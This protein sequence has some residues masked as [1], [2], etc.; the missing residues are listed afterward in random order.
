LRL[1]NRAR[2]TNLEKFLTLRSITSIA[3]SESSSK[4]K[5]KSVAGK[6]AALFFSRTK[7]FGCDFARNCIG[8]VPDVCYKPWPDF[9]PSPEGFVLNQPHLN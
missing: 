2:S 5:H 7:T 1:R 3:Q 9:I 6:S 4:T 8:K